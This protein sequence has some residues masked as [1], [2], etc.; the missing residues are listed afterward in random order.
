MPKGNVN[1]GK[2]S[3]RRDPINPRYLK[4]NN[5]PKFPITEIINMTFGNQG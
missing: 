2:S 5:I 3:E 4:K 1:V